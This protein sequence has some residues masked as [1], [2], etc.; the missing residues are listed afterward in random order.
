ML[1]SLDDVGLRAEPPSELPE[2]LHRAVLIPRPRHEQGRIRHAAQE[3]EISHPE[4]RRH[5]REGGNG[6]PGRDHPGRDPCAERVAGEP[7]E[8][9]RREPPGHHPEG[10]PDVVLLRL[11]RTML[12]R[13]SAHSAEIEAEGRHLQSLGDLDYTDD[14]GVV[15]V[16]AVEGVGVAYDDA[17]PG[18]VGE[19]KTG[20][21]PGAI[22]NVKSYRRF[23]DTTLRFPPQIIKDAGRPRAWRYT[24]GH[25]EPELRS[26]ST[27]SRATHRR[28]SRPPRDP[29]RHQPPSDLPHLP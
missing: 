18:A 17:S 12:A 27:P 1:R 2:S 15:H 28:R 29:L 20:L 26:G 11:A 10:C 21:E 25:V 8:A 19:C 6:L 16:A 5:E 24:A 14:H 9:P 22:T 7:H 3:V 4:G 13:R 23:H